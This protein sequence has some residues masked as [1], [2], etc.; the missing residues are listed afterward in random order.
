MEDR[1]IMEL[2]ARLEAS[3][4]ADQGIVRSDFHIDEKLKQQ[5]DN[6]RSH[7][8]GNRAGYLRLAILFLRAASQPV[9]NPDTAI[10]DVAQ[11]HK[12]IA[13]FD[14]QWL[15]RREDV[16]PEKAPE[17]Y[18]ENWRDKVS[19]IFISLILACLCIWLVVGFVVV[20][21]WIYLLLGV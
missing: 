17:P 13:I 19:S 18:V 16:E 11:P 9:K 7:A 1:E 2:A 5:A 21:R 20:A 12:D 3:L 10:V 15:E 4:F 8:I 14:H 6:F